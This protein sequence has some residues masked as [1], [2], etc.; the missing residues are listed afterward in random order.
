MADKFKAKTIHV[1]KDYNNI[2]L[3]DPNKVDVDKTNSNPEGVED[4]LVDH[5]DLVMYANLETKVIPRTK[6]ANGD[7]FDII[8]TT[9]ASF[10]SGS[11]DV[12][13]NFLKLSISA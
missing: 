10:D 12:N 1:E 13:L 8:N 9:I 3:I 2:I 7:S 4:R 6:L 5:E 11:K